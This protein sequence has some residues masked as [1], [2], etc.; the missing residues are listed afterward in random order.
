MDLGPMELIIIFAVFL[1]LFGANKLPSLGEGLG[2]ALRSFK[3]AMRGDGEG[4]SPPA[5][6]NG[7]PAKAEPQL[8]PAGPQAQVPPAG[9]SAEPVEGDG[10]GAG[11]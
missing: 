7:A 3:E 9:Q 2:K 6:P 10:K 5:P 4:A 8:P 11:S 1:L